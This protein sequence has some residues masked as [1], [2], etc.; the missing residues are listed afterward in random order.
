MASR[1]GN[2]HNYRISDQTFSRVI[3]G[4][5]AVSGVVLTGWS[6][7]RSTQIFSTEVARGA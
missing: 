7:A 1:L 2:R 3:L 4:L 5:L 6:P